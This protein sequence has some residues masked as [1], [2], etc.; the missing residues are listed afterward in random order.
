[1]T[2]VY[3][4]IRLDKNE[5]FYIGIGTD[6]NYQRAYS[7]SSRNVLWKKVVNVTDYQVEIIMD[8]L[9][10]DIA[11]QKEIEF[12]LL[13]GKKINKTGTLVNITDGGESGSGFKHTQEA[14]KR[15]GEASKL[16][17]YSK[18][19]KSYT[20]TQEYRDKISKINKGRKMPDSMREKTSLR[21]KNRVLSEEHKEKLRNLRLGVKATNETKE[22]MRL[23]SYIGWEK[24]KNKNI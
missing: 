18:Y 14:K 4:H 21:M 20:Q 7:K 13:Y 2:Y 9:T 5:P 6:T 10:K 23:S 3:R 1:M 24:R 8:N 12:I 22:K 19:D 16:K 15:I 11:K 17:D